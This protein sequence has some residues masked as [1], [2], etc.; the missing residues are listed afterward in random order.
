MEY[1]SPGYKDVLDTLA[2]NLARDRRAHF[3]AQLQDNSGEHVIPRPRVEL[4]TPQA[5]AE[6]V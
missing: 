2:E 6:I 4:S 3:L 1:V 5:I